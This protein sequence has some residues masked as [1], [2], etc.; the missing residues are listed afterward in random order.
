MKNKGI[1]L[2]D[3]STGL[4]AIDL[5]IDVVRDADGL[6]TQGMVIGDIMNQNQALILI[7]NPGEFKFNPTIGVSID[8]ILLNDD[9]LRMRHRIREHLEKDGMKVKEIDFS[10]SKPLKINASYE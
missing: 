4:Q 3:S 9:Y 10:Q 2:A 5:K 8:E 7:A 6:I 1:Q